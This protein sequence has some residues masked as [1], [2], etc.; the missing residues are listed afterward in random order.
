MNIDIARIKPE[1][2][3]DLSFLQITDTHLFKDLEGA[4]LGIK[5]LESFDSV[6]EH[7]LEYAP[8]VGGILATGDISQDQS[9]TSYR[10]FSDQINRFS[11]P[12]YNLPGNHDVQPVMQNCLLSQGLFHPQVIESDFWII[13]LLD[14]QV[15]GKPYGFLNDEQLELIEQVLE[16]NQKKANAKNVLICVHHNVLKVGSAWL[17]QHILRNRNEFLALIK[18]YTCV[19]AVLSGH[20]HQESDVLHENVRFITSP[21]TGVQFKPN[22][23]EFATDSQAPGYRHLVLT[24][25]GEIDTRVFR[26]SE[27]LFT[28]DEQAKGY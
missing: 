12:C 24:K 5:T 27:G 19:K 14:S 25:T 28:C 20:V 16:E 15:A 2:N 9:K 10:H 23:D 4:L 17:D 26:I 13:L 1:S 6:I 18:K 7:A 11:V 21:S 22:S 8:S 3:G